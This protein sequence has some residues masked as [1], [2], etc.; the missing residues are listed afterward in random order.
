MKRQSFLYYYSQSSLLKKKYPYITQYPQIIK[1]IHNS[2]SEP[3][4]LASI[5]TNEMPWIKE[6]Y[7]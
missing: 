5:W 2:L 3:K 1:I 7:L 6:K 4:Q